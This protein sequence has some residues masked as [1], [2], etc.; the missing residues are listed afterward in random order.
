MGFTLKKLSVDGFL[1]K[2]KVV[3]NFKQVNV[4]VGK[5]GSGKTSLLRIINTLLKDHDDSLSCM[6][7]SGNAYSYINLPL[8]LIPQIPLIPVPSRPLGEA[9]RHIAKIYTS[10]KDFPFQLVEN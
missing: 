10:S 2:K 6:A 1:R 9:C 7:L 8:I 4:L 3:W 5:N